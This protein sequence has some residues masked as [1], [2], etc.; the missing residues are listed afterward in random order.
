M[1]AKYRVEVLLTGW[2]ERFV[3]ADSLAA[4]KRLATEPGWVGEVG[5]QR[6]DVQGVTQVEVL[7]DDGWQEAEA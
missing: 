4:A 3:E 7:T 1:M 6:V 5:D 2:Q